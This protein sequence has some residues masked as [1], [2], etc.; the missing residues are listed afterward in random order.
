MNG[1]CL[2]PACTD[3]R[4]ARGW[5]VLHFF[6]WRRHGDPMVVLK[7]KPSSRRMVAA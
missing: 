4:F 2:V 3:A 6:R 5:C 1:P 7:Y